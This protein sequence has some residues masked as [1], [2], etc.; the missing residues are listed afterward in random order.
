MYLKETWCQMVLRQI[1]GVD[2]PI[3]STGARCAHRWELAL[4]IAIF[5]DPEHNE[6]SSLSNE[7]LNDRGI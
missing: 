3:S 2:L 5:A 4:G 7:T 6:F 1:F